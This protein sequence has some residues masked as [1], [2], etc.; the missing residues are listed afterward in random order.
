M[1]IEERFEEVPVVTARFDKPYGVLPVQKVEDEDQNVV[2]KIK[3][4]SLRILARAMRVLT[5]K[6]E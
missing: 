3:T 1:A 4:D 2:G 5:S 6:D